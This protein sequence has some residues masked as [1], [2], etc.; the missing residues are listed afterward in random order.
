MTC[1]VQ[2]AAV[3]L[4]HE[5]EAHALAYKAIKALPGIPLLSPLPSHGRFS[6]L[7]DVP[8]LRLGHGACNNAPVSTSQMP[9][10]LVGSGALG[11]QRKHLA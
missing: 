6:V 8:C 3:Y 7:P 11:A 1:V 4:R 9:A 10:L 5:L 2:E